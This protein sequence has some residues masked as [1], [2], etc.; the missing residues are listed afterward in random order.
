[1]THATAAHRLQVR[2]HTVMYADGKEMIRIVMLTGI[3]TLPDGRVAYLPRFVRRS[4]MTMGE[5][6]QSIIDRKWTWN[7]RQFEGD[8][9]YAPMS[10][11]L[12]KAFWPHM[13][14]MWGVCSEGM[15]LYGRRGRTV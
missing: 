6:H 3:R 11:E 15:R 4:A 10:K 9:V 8:S 2:D 7:D 1:M 5:L 12:V 13:V 14:S